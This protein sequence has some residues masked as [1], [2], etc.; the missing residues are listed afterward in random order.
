M[1]PLLQSME[2][3]KPAPGFN[4]KWGNLAKM[5]SSITGV[6][7]ALRASAVNQDA[8]GVTNIKLDFPRYALFID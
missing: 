8:G 7:A 6:L 3:G 1:G 2:A 4:D 5:R